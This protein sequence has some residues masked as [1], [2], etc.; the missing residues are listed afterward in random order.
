MA[1]QASCARMSTDAQGHP[2]GWSDAEPVLPHCPHGP[3]IGHLA[4]QSDFLEDNNVEHLRSLA[5][6]LNSTL[7]SCFLPRQAHQVKRCQD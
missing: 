7:A 6:T 3:F 2:P 1:T 5:V 4:T